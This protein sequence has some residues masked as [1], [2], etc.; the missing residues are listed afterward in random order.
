MTSTFQSVSPSSISPRMPSGL[1]C[2]TSPGRAMAR[3]IS[4]ASRGS[5]SPGASAGLES[6]MS[7][8]Y[9]VSNG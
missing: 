8:D 2:L 7:V 9:A 5:S 6:R 3:P 4:Q 1:T